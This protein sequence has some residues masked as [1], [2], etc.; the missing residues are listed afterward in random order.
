MSILIIVGAVL[1]NC[2]QIILDYVIKINLE[3]AIG[4]LYSKF[5]N[6]AHVALGI[7]L[8]IVLKFIFT[9]VFKKGYPKAIKNLCKYS[10]KYSYDIYLVHQFIILGPLS[11]MRLTGVFAIN[12]FLIMAIIVI[13][14]TLVNFI[15]TYLRAKLKKIMDG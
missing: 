9:K 11:L 5:C 15:S 1:S 13:S 2:I 3:G 8:F 4:L 6:F 14:S 7:M 10:D 12:I